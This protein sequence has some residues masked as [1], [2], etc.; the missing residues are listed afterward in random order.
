[1][2]K[3]N[4]HQRIKKDPASLNEASQ[5]HGRDALRSCKRAASRQGTA[6]RA[7]GRWRAAAGAGWQRANIARR[8]FARIAG[9]SES[10]TGA[11]MDYCTLLRADR[12]LLGRL[13]VRSTSGC[14]GYTI[15]RGGERECEIWQSM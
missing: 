11:T 2:R 13:L 3:R 5:W 6:G 4:T 7:G 8:A 10:G 12:R 9:A 14:D 1:M 15:P